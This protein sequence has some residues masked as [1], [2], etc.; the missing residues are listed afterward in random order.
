MF[1][2]FRIIHP[3]MG[4][5]LNQNRDSNPLLPKI[6]GSEQEGGRYIHPLI[7]E[8]N[9]SVSKTRVTGLSSALASVK[10]IRVHTFL[11]SGIKTKHSTIP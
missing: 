7:R 2:I 6:T 1:V 5:C 3:Q 11:F 10:G 4:L 8:G 9:I